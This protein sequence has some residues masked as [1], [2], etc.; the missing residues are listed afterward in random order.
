MKAPSIPCLIVKAT[1]T[2]LSSDFFTAADASE[3]CNC[4]IEK[5]LHHYLWIYT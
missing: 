5:C 1:A 3:I 2:N 4:P